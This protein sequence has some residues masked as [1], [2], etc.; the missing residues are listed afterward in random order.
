M[1]DAEFVQK[2]AMA[3]LAEVAMGEMAARKAVG[4]SVRDFA[5]RMV[6]DHNRAN[7]RLKE[8]AGRHGI[9]LP[10]TL[11]ETH[12]EEE[13]RLD[14]LAGDSFDLEYVISQV[15]AHE[16]AVT[17]FRS[18][19]ESDG[20]DDLRSFARDTLPILE[21]HLRLAQQ[22]RAAEGRAGI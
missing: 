7:D 20:S 3:G 13:R 17:L 2:A 8:I 9:P 1:Q 5:R 15:A 10:G 22:L 21:K 4:T 14:A 18:Y 16:Q 6:Q 11:D 12:A 19:A